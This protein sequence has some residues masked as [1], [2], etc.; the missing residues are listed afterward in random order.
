MQRL[1]K[2][3]SLLIK[4]D[5]QD[6]AWWSWWSWWRITEWHV[7]TISQR[8]N[9]EKRGDA[10]SDVVWP[11]TKVSTT[12]QS[13]KFRNTWKTGA[14]ADG[15]W[16]QPLGPRRF[17]KAMETLTCGSQLGTSSFQHWKVMIT[18]AAEVPIT[19]SQATGLRACVPQWWSWYEVPSCPAL[20]IC[21]LCM[22]FSLGLAVFSFFTA[23]VLGTGRAFTT[24]CCRCFA[25]CSSCCG[26][27]RELRILICTTMTSGYHLV[28][29][30]AQ[31][32]LSSTQ[33]GLEHTWTYLNILEHTW[34]YL[35]ILERAAV[36]GASATINKSGIFWAVCE[37]HSAK[38]PQIQANVSSVFSVQ[39][40]ELFSPCC[41]EIL[42][43]CG[44]VLLESRGLQAR[45][46]KKHNAQAAQV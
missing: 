11:Q 43:H 29:S 44:D 41:A 1:R 2:R 6:A 26:I 23:W 24:A 38:G 25:C 40:G 3:P 5:D 18:L 19:T 37:L 21:R 36:A 33:I 35:N 30:K 7:L 12:I 22:H 14:V 42:I 28:M 20:H 39:R 4:Q 13:F 8:K 16:L 32:A 45:A 34:T 9:F 27:A 31:N 46:G 10:G 15:A 17:L